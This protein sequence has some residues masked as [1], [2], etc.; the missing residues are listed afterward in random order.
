MFTK[1]LAANATFIGLSLLVA[2][3]S[4][5]SLNFQYSQCA[6]SA[7]EVKNLSAGKISINL[8]RDSAFSFDHR[9]S[10]GIR[11]L[12]MEIANPQSGESLGKFSCHVN[13]KGAVKTVKFLSKAS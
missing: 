13:S 1:R 5:A 11:I 8:G 2:S 12:K 10:R 7:L 6:A 3:P 4:F 9:G